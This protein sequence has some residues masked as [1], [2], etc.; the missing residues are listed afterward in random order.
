MATAN[1]LA[2]AEAGADAVS[3]T[4]NGLGERAGNAPLE[5]VVVALSLSADLS[6]RVR[7]PNLNH[8]C[9]YV[10]RI[11]GRPLPPDKPITGDS[12]FRHESGIHCHAMLRDPGTYQPFPAETVGRRGFQ[13]ALGAHSGASAIRYLLQKAGIEV[14]EEMVARLKSVL[15]DD[16]PALNGTGRD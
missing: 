16:I 15:A 10:A 8:L 3:V 12:V 2:A 11:S 13:F 4:V 7:T 6:C 14:S 5:Q 1:A 9:S